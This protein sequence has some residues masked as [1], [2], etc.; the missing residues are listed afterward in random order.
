MILAW[1]FSRC[2]VVGIDSQKT[3]LELAKKRLDFYGYTYVSFFCSPSSGHLPE[4]IDRYDDIVLSSVY[5][6]LLPEERFALLPMIL[7]KL[8]RNRILFV[9]QTPDKRFP[10]EAHTSSLPLINY[11]PSTWVCFLIQKFSRQSLR[12][13]SWSVL[14]RRGIR[15]ATDKE[16]LTILGNNSFASEEPV[17]LKL[18]MLGMRRQSDIWYSI[19]LE[20][21]EVKCKG[22]K[23]YFLLSMFNLIMK[24]KIPLAPYLSL[25]FRKT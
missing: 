19:A 2:S 1:M 12:D 25:A 4:G 18:S 14:L 8:S 23:K 10:I 9:N 16:I 20:R 15:G 21:L 22:L 11:L 24:L 7:R 3:D 6:H 5:E 17:I 13:E